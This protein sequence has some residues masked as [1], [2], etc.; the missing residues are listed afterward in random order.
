MQTA[1]DSRTL[2]L[3]RPR[4]Q[5]RL[6][7]LERLVS[8]LRS[9]QRTSA[10]GSPTNS[11]TA[12]QSSSTHPKPGLTPEH[13]APLVSKHMDDVSDC[14]SMYITPSEHRY[15]SGDHW[16]AILDT[17]AD[18]K[19]HFD[20][21]ERIQLLHSANS[22]GG[23]GGDFDNSEHLAAGPR[24]PHCLLLYASHR[25]A[26]RSEIL[27]ALPPKA[28]VDR[29]IAK[30]FNNLDLYEE[31]WRNPSATPIN[32]IG[33]LF[34]MICLAVMVSETTSTTPS[35]PDTDAVQ[36]QLQI[37]LYREKLV[38][39]LIMGKYTK[40]GP[41]VLEAFIQYVY[42]EFGIRADADKDIFLLAIEVNLAM[43]MGY[44]RDPS[45]FPE[46]SPLQGEMRRR[47]WA[48][49]MLGDIL[50][51]GQMGMPRMLCQSQ[52]DTTEPRNLNDAD[53]DADTAELPPAR[54]ETENTTALGIIARH[55]L[56]M[57]L[58][59][60]SDLTASVQPCSYAEIMRVDAILLAA[61]ANIPPPL[62]SKPMAASLTDSPQIIMARLF[63]SHIFYRGQIMLHRRFLYTDPTEAEFEYSRKSCLDASLRT[64]EI[65]HVMD[66][67]TCAGGQLYTMKWRVTSILNHQ[68]LT[69][70]MIL[71]SLLCRQCTMGREQEITA[72]L[73]KTKAVWM[74]R[75]VWSSEAK[76]AAE[77]VS[78]ALARANNWRDRSAMQEDEYGGEGNMSNPVKSSSSYMGETEA[79]VEMGSRD[80]L[81]SNM[82]LYDPDQ[83]LM[84][85]SFHNFAPTDQQGQNYDFTM[86]NIDPASTS[87]EAWMSVN[88]PG[89]GW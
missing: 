82:G 43:R 31:F 57:A 36:Q 47:L 52:C 13:S 60:V 5:D 65:Q 33:L 7:H 61:A 12:P 72:A 23:I 24:L 89:T 54:P 73:W 34:G 86:N 10:N 63:L 11:P 38:Q 62:K 1:G 71:C 46:I 81:Q 44:H 79:G 18:L 17:I 84:H 16:A 37:D 22:N 69:A 66:E 27:A 45:H 51:S 88:S 39:C 49:V 87:M 75:S 50:I 64:L 48:T 8:S 28:A 70:T 25:P 58:G 77:T 14:G 19:D 74:R 9:Q 35:T 78:F 80:P 3:A 85:S 40:C 21:E 15:V 83:F 55:R 41:Y 56:L 32:W 53:L 2:P 59:T 42:V 76:K 68:F 6:V 4:L 20:Q 30:Y 26:S 67:E 29:Y